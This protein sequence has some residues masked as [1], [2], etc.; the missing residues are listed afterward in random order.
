MKVKRRNGRR[1]DM[2]RR[3]EME[4]VAVFYPIVYLFIGV[5][6]LF[7]LLYVFFIVFPIIVLLYLSKVFYCFVYCYFLSFLYL[8]LIFNSFR[9]LLLLYGQKQNSYKKVFMQQ[10]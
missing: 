8:I 4:V 7:I 5:H 2:V 6:C 10:L 9:G 3:R 1:R